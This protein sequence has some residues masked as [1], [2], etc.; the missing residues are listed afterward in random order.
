MHMLETMG[1][2]VMTEPLA[3]LRW[4]SPR[5]RYPGA[6]PEGYRLSNRDRKPRRLDRG[7]R[8]RCRDVVKPLG[9]V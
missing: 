1:L 3:V 6:S 4:A 8:R 9:P 5:A 2:V 7:S